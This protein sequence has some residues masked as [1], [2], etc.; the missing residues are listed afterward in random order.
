MKLKPNQ[1]H[2][3]CRTCKQKDLQNCI[4]PI[5]EFIED[6]KRFPESTILSK[7]LHHD[8]KSCREKWKKFRAARLRLYEERILAKKDPM[9]RMTVHFEEAGYAKAMAIKSKEKGDKSLT[10]MNWKLYSEN[11]S[12]GQKLLKLFL[13]GTT[14]ENRMFM[15]QEFELKMEEAPTCHQC[16]RP[17]HTKPDCPYD[18]SGM[19]EET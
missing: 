14:L 13:E 15:A 17:G 3:A 9:I 2:R 6:H 7:R 16:G 10:A 19:P 18:P 4:K 11:R 1:T 8:C 12:K 5:E